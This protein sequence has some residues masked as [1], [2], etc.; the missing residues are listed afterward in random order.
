MTPSINRLAD[1][2]KALGQYILEHEW[3]LMEDE[4]LRADINT[5]E[6]FKR[7]VTGYQ[8]Y[9]A[10]VCDSGGQLDQINSQLEEDWEDLQALQA[11]K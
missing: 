5:L 10:L 8:Y 3:E 4:F 2:A 6:Q 1:S 7:W 11:L 9:N